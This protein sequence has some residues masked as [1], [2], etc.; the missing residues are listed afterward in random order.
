MNRL[1]DLLNSG[2]MDTVLKDDLEKLKIQTTY[3][4]GMALTLLFINN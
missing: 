1:R 3:A 2:K 4:E